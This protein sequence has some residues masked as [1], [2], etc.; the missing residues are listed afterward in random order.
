M[1]KVTES[2]KVETGIKEGEEEIKDLEP[3]SGEEI[4]ESA[5]NVTENSTFLKSISTRTQIAVEPSSTNK[6]KV[7]VTTGRPDNPA[8][9]STNSLVKDHDRS[10][11]ATV[12]T[13]SKANIKGS[14]T[15]SPEDNEVVNKSSMTASDNIDIESSGS[16][17]SAFEFDYSSK[18]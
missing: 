4:V 18:S 11:N 7:A 5:L 15:A 3:K 1:K 8:V 10:S 16:F 14:A 2:A 13:Y 12:I 9:A 17:T 6:T